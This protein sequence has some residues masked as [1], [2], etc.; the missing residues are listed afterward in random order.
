MRRN[1]KVVFQPGTYHSFRLG[2]DKI[3]DAIRPTLGPV[4]RQVAIA[5]RTRTDRPELLDSGGMIARRLLEFPDRSEDMGAM[6]VRHLIWRQYEQAGDGAATAAVL[7]QSLFNQGARYIAAGGNTQRLRLHLE[8]AMCHVLDD[9]DARRFHVEG[10]AR[11][12]GIAESICYDPP[13]AATLGEIFDI[14]GGFGRVD[15]RPGRSDAIEREYVEGMYW[16]QSGVLSRYMYTD[17]VRSRVEL[18]D[19]AIVISDLEIHEPRDLAPLVLMAQ[20]AG[21]RRLV[22][23]VSHLA[24]AAIPWVLAASKDLDKL[25][26]IAVKTPEVHVDDQAAALEDLAVLAGGRPL[27]RAAGDSLRSI[28]PDHLG[29]ARRV[30]ADRNY[31][32]IIGGKG[33]PRLLRRHLAQ[34][35]ERFKVLD[36]DES[37]RRTEKR[38]GKLLGGSA[39]LWV[40]GNADHH[41]EM[42]KEL[43]E[44]TAT[45]MRGALR[46]GVVAGGGVAMLQCRHSLRRML[47]QTTDPDARAAYGCLIH[48]LGEPF[49]TIVANA[50]YEPRSVL[51]RDP[52][53]EQGLG[54][55]ART[56]AVVDV[57]AAGIFDAASVVSSAVRTAISGAALA[58]TIDVLVH[59]KRRE[60]SINP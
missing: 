28:K 37:R 9:L 22:L 8:A 25:H 48:A 51:A 1:Q 17:E 38:I 56:G 18:Q 43:A 55:D 12:A 2:I 27:L 20:Q 5:P 26:M 21:I 50:G 47:E 44:R 19:A 45:A 3:V 15:I 52:H 41:I 29:H 57:A 31:L 40:G 58:L 53:G 36:D 13:L 24:D 59:S 32:G 23:L 11:L 14:V 39:T 6:F 30:W 42:R 54:L 33:D 35:K 4:P 49:R 7:F 34:L 10:K 46:E 16:E 60:V